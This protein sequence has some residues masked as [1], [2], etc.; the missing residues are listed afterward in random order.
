VGLGAEH[1]VESTGSAQLQLTTHL[2]TRRDER[3]SWLGCIRP[4]GVARI[5]NW[6]WRELTQ[7]CENKKTVLLMPSQ[8]LHITNYN[9]HYLYELRAINTHHVMSQDEIKTT[10]SCCS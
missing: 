1:P 5:F 2:S 9:A 3:L 8:F 10:G 7:L 4:I 6:G